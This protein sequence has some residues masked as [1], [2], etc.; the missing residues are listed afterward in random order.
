MGQICRP[1][2]QCCLAGGSKTT[3][4][5]FSIAMGADYSIEVK[6]IEIWVPT[7]FKHNNSSL[8]TV[9]NK[10]QVLCKMSTIVQGGSWSKLGN[11]W[12]TIVIECPPLDT[13]FSQLCAYSYIVYIAL[14]QG[15][16]SL[17]LD[18]LSPSIQ[19]SCKNLLSLSELSR[20]MSQQECIH[21][22]IIWYVTS[23]R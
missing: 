17:Q 5:I 11:I 1:N 2:W 15:C 7:F 3:P 18:S 20:Q 22:Q 8:A 10:G 4:R 6:I 12:S 16:Y 13:Y 14:N 23:T 21:M 9:V 19:R